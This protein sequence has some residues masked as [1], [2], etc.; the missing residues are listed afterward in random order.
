MKTINYFKISGFLFLGLAVAALC[1]SM[2][3]TSLADDEAGFGKQRGPRA[4]AGPHAGPAGRPFGGIMQAL[5][6]LDLDEAQ[7]ESLKALFEQGRAEGIPL[8]EQLAQ[9]MDA[10]S[11]AH[12]NNADDTTLNQAIDAVVAAHQALY[13]H[14]MDIKEQVRAVLSP[15]QQAELMLSFREG[16]QKRQENR[17]RQRGQRGRGGQDSR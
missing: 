1:L 3:G 16:R 9:S 15:A 10:L 12:E 17:A 2:P 5:R 13:E 4:G 8:R 11:K 6:T 7:R 14:R